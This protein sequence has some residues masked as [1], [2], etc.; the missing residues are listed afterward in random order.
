MAKT[1]DKLPPVVAVSGNHDF[2]RDRFL[3]QLLLRLEKEGRTTEWVDAAIPEA[4]SGALSGGVLTDDRNQIVVE[5]PQAADLTLLK[6]HQDDGINSTIVILYSTKNLAGNT[7]YAKWV[8]ANVPGHNVFESPEKDKDYKWVDPARAF[9]LDEVKAHDLT[10]KPALANAL[11]DRIGARYFG[12]LAYEIQ[13]AAILAKLRGSTVIEPEDLSTLAQIGEA[14]FV[15]L[16]DALAGRDIKAV[17]KALDRIGSTHKGATISVCR[18]LDGT[19]LKWLAAASFE[20][21]GLPRHDVAALLSM[22][23]WFYSNRVRPTVLAWG[24]RDL[25]RLLAAF[26]VSERAART[27]C[28]EPWQGLVSRVLAVTSPVAP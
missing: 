11:V 13:K 10:M 19:L 12:F 23:E 24:L 6:E 8:K 9:V 25:K 7:K 28:T 14:S 22:N 26:T 27:G 18:F 3:R 20:A 2:P 21:Q 16:S 4:L 5:N 1:S 17:S 15:L